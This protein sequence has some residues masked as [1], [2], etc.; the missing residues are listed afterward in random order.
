M[1]QLVRDKDEDIRR[2]AIEILNQ[3]KDERAVDHLIDATKDTDWWVSERAVDALAEIGSKRAV[4]RLI[5]M[6]R[7][8]RPR[9]RCP[10]WCARSASSATTRSSMPCCP[11]LARPRRRSASRRITPLAKLADE[12]RVE[13][14]RV[15]LQAQTPA[16]DQTIAQA[17]LRALSELDSRFSTVARASRRRRIVRRRLA[18]HRS[19]GS[20]PGVEHAGDGSRPAFRSARPRVDAP[21]PPAPP[22]AH[23]AHSQQART[24]LMSEQDVQRAAKQAEKMAGPRS[25]TSRRS[26]PA[27]SSRAATSTSNA[28]A[29]APSAPCC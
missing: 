15:Q 21:P 23:A 3:T 20:A 24:Q 26:S 19:Q 29:R 13:Q 28:S 18:V 12:R 9:N 27:T 22:P 16:A 8:R 10:S 2:A 11:A 5:E 17:A 25:S 14:I 1:L 7:A 4:P 6:L